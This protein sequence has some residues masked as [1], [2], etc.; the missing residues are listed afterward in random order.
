[1][2]KTFRMLGK[3]GNRSE[4]KEMQPVAKPNSI[5]TQRY[6]ESIGTEERRFGNCSGHQSIPAGISNI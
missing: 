1:M 6:M 2:R 4:E 3:E 5:F